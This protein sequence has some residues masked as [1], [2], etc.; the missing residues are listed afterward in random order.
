MLSSGTHRATRRDVLKIAGLSAIA[1]LATACGQTPSA[2]PSAAPSSPS[3]ATTTE[4]AATPSAVGKVQ[5]A[6]AKTNVGGKVVMWAF[7]LTENDT[8]QIWN[9]LVKKFAEEYPNV[10]VEVQ[11]QSWTGRREK[12]LAAAA[13]NATPDMAY[14]NNDMVFAFAQA[15]AIVPLDDYL[16]SVAPNLV[17]EYPKAV[18]DGLMY[19]GKLFM[20]PILSGAV[21]GLYNKELYAE[22]GLDPATPP[23]SV[24]DLANLGQ[25]AKAKGYYGF[26]YRSNG[27]EM[28]NSI[29][30]G[31]GGTMLTEDHTRSLWDSEPAIEMFRFVQTM[32]KEEWVPKAGATAS[33]DAAA[34]AVSDY[35]VQKKQVGTEYTSSMAIIQQYQTQIPDATFGVMEVFKRADGTRK[36]TPTLGCLGIFNA[37][38]NKDGAAVWLTWLLKPDNLAFYNTQGGFVP[39]TAKAREQWNV[40]EVTKAWGDQVQYIVADQ[41]IQFYYGN[42]I[43]FLQPILSAVALEQMT[44][45]EAGKQAAQ[46]VNDYIKQNP[47]T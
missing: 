10:A 28:T 8:E 5:T 46:Q 19:E 40:D 1:L 16:K 4:G 2:S 37:G 18:I 7:P 9:P 22:I 36:S 32:F 31:L 42:H 12:M 20:L 33:G 27:F 21:C 34:A 13:A 6:P 38:E 39:P 43:T 3:A 17:A 30:Y 29:L 15:G 25:K 41:D 26:A 44:P 24:D 11:M 23:A 45:E 47:L 35:F 14:L